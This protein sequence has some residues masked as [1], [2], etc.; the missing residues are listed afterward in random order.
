MRGRGASAVVA[1]AALALAGEPAAHAQLTAPLASCST[2]VDDA[3]ALG[4]S[5]SQRDVCITGQGG[6]RLAATIYKSSLD[7]SRSAARRPFV[8]GTHGWGH[9]RARNRRHAMLKGIFDALLARGYH[10]LLYDSRGWGDSE[11]AVELNWTEREGADAEAVVAHV[12]RRSDA[13]LDAA[14]DARLGWIG[15]SYAGGIQY[16]AAPRIDGP[17]DA[18]VP[19]MTYGQLDEDLAPNGV[20]RYWNKSLYDNDGGDG[21]GSGLGAWTAAHE[22][23]PGY[24]PE[25]N[26]WGSDVKTTAS[27]SPL[28][29]SWLASRASVHGSPAIRTPTLIW[30]QPDDTLFP[31]QAAL[32]NHRV[33]AASSPEIPLKLLLPCSGHTRCVAPAGS[34]GDPN[35]N[36]HLPRPV[37]ETRVLQWFERHVG[38]DAS[39]DTGPAVEWEAADGYFRAAA[40][41]PVAGSSEQAFGGELPAGA[42]ALRKRDSVSGGDTGRYVP[43][44]RATAEPAENTEGSVRF[45]AGVAPNHERDEGVAVHVRLAGARAPAGGCVHLLGRPRLALTGTATVDGHVFAQLFARLPG[46][47][48]RVLHQQATPVRVA[49]G[50]V[51]LDLELDALAETLDPSVELW[52]ELTSGSFMFSVLGERSPPRSA[53]AAADASEPFLDVAGLSA[54]L[55]WR[56]DPGAWDGTRCESDAFPIQAPGSNPPPEPAR[57][58]VGHWRFDDPAAPGVDSSGYEVRHDG[59]LEGATEPGPNLLAGDGG[60]IAFLSPSGIL[61]VADDP[62]LRPYDGAWSVSA[63][64]NLRAA[65]QISAIYTKRANVSP[66]EQASFFVAD[67]DTATSPSLIRGRKLCWWH[68]Q[69]ASVERIACTH[70]AVANGSAR[71]V[72]GVAEP[73][74]GAIRLYVDGTPMAARTVAADGAWPNLS[75]AADVQIGG[76][77]DVGAAFAGTSLAPAASID[78][79]LDEVRAYNVALTDAQVAE[80]HSAPRASDVPACP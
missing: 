2:R 70:D 18:F 63:L 39:V 56:P 33:V 42:I 28:T 64:V 32:A 51:D 31:L 53:A 65:D 77:A 21:P 10:V 1:I 44:T 46:Q 4:A 47:P 35:G 66:H 22:K 72:A 71:W 59:T 62:T 75:A 57:G 41:Y 9:D 45:V 3:S 69:S 36:L 34:G 7:A 27:F 40:S 15:G 73:A 23:L 38:G 55:P 52:V 13:L 43:P 50:A 79:H 6:V 68:R 61:R 29:R 25:V 24:S 16:A 17:V 20:V 14:G 19:M 48:D 74:T 49:A 11:G 30:H 80:L 37:Q 76:N 54:T 8:V 12:A 5:E 58:L 67:F 78:C 60:S 26:Q